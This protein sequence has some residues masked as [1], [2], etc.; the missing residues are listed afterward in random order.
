MVKLLYKKLAGEVVFGT[1][2]VK[3]RYLNYK[4]QEAIV[5]WLLNH[6]DVEETPVKEEN[7]S[8]NS[9]YF[10]KMGGSMP[11][12]GL[13]QYSSLQVETLFEIHVTF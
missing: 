8:R 12:F 7:G 11:L 10:K 5:R 13:F 6:T 2:V 3:E 4:I 1:V 9:I